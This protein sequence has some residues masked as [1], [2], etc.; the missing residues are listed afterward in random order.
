MGF[1][2]LS[3]SVPWFSFASTSFDPKLLKYIVGNFEIERV[4]RAQTDNRKI[5][6]TKT[7]W[8]GT[9]QTEMGIE[10]KKN[11]YRR[12][13]SK[14]NGLA[15]WQYVYVFEWRTCKWTVQ[16]CAYTSNSFFGLRLNLIVTTHYNKTI[17]M[18][19]M[20]RKFLTVF[21]GV[22]SSRFR[23]ILYRFI[24]LRF[25]IHFPSLFTRSLGDQRHA[26][27]VHSQF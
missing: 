18:F 26:L 13:K 16:I 8:N 6:H 25:K 14:N 24:L 22:F 12:M 20:R 19:L 7:N 10:K 3:S 27:W 1:V 5:K 21:C 15:L 11:R 4:T 2:S 23:H 17:I 9:N